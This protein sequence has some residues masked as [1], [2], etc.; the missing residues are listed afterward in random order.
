MSSTIT[1]RL[2][3][4]PEDPP[5]QSAGV[6]R[7]EPGGRAQR[8]AGAACRL[9]AAPDEPE[10]ADRVRQSLPDGVIDELLAGA[11][12]EQ[13]ITGHGGL[14]GQLTSGWWSARWRSS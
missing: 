12:T 6:S 10:L 2:D 3:E 9:T 8:R 7:S 4:H 14:L 5:D 11:S 1:A 13:D